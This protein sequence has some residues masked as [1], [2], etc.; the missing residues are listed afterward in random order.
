MPL[1][2]PITVSLPLNS[3]YIFFVVL[4]PLALSVSVFGPNKVVCFQIKF[5]ASIKGYS[6]Y[7]FL[8]WTFLAFFLH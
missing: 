4:A 1:K 3:L 7:N 6:Y 8:V 5:V 2:Y